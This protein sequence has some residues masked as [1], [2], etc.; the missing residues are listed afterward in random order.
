MKSQIAKAIQ[1]ETPQE[2]RDRVRDYG[3]EV[4]KRREAEIEETILDDEEIKY[5]L[6]SGKSCKWHRER[7]NIYWQE[8]EQKK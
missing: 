1:D 4:I 6:W 7:N 8:K 3:H 5:A 2:V